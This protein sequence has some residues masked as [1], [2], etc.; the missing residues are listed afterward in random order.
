MTDRKF[1][2][3]VVGGQLRDV[4]QWTAFA[5]RVEDAGFATM[6]V[7]D[8]FNVS[9]PFVALASAATVTTQL[10]LGTFVLATPLRTPGSIAWESASLDRLSGGRFELG[11]G[12]GRPDAAA[13]ADVL[14]LPWGSPA[15]RVEQLAEAIRGVRAVFATAADVAARDGGRPLGGYDYLR[16]VQQPAPPMLVAG[17]GRKVLTLAAR[18]ADIVGLGVSAD[19]GED[20][21]AEKV[22]IVRDAA[23]DRFD[24][25][26]LSFNIFSA[27][28]S[29]IPP[30]MI[31]RFGVDP[32]KIADNQSLAVLTGSPDTMADVLQ[33]RRDRFGIS[34]VSVNAMAMEAFAP[35]VERLAGR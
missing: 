7:P 13:E 5:R 28:E 9:S 35:V 25:L 33:R 2:F 6:L 8:T 14:G 18:E 3:G 22:A 34:Y 31:E 27:G 4:A 23:G 24:E 17:A 21:L 12:A 10:R 26:E 29:E 16:P 20:V 11:M 30:W 1:R 15:R 32:A 19:S